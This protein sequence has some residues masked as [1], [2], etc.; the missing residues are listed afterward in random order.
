MRLVII[1]AI[2][3]IFFIAAKKSERFLFLSASALVISIATT[4]CRWHIRPELFSLLFIVVFIY[5]LKSYKGK[6]SIFFLFP[7]QV[8]WVNLHGYF[9]IGPI[10]LFIFLAARTA[11]ANLK[12]PFRWNSSK[13]GTQA[14]KK[15]VSVFFLLIAVSILNPY[16]F[17]G[18]AY[19]VNVF[20]SAIEGFFGG[21]YAF[22]SVSEL[23]NIPITHIILRPNFSLLSAVIILFFVS[24]LLN[25]KRADIFDLILFILFL[26]F[27]TAANRHIG[28]LALSLGILTIFNLNSAE[29]EK[30]F[31]QGIRRII[32]GKFLLR[33]VSI[34][35][36][37]F[38]IYNLFN[39][40]KGALSVF[41]KRYIYNLNCDTKS[42]MFGKNEF[43]FNQPFGAAEF[44]KENRIRAN[45]FNFFN[46]GAYLIFALYP[47]CRVFID[48]RTEVYGDTFL[49]TWHKIRQ[50]PELIDKIKSNLDI[51]CVVLPCA[52]NFT[53]SFFKYL[54]NSKEW[55]LVFF[56]GKSSVFL[57]DNTRFK[58]II[59]K[60]EVNLDN[61]QVNPDIALI[62]AAREE[63]LYPGIFISTA[64]FFYEIDM[65][66]KGLEVI[67]IAEQIMPAN[68]AIYNLKAILLL[69]LNRPKE[70][71]SQF[72]KAL[73]LQPRNPEI[74]KNIGG[75]YLER[76]KPDIA[77]KYFETGL[78][79]DPRNKKLKELLELL[80]KPRTDQLTHK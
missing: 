49:R 29:R 39:I 72:I 34:I 76:G 73:K 10:I 44:L 59:E 17:K 45:M 26:F 74:Y 75:F 64:N 46:H 22:S 36:M 57:A 80:N 20:F 27:T 68:Y 70:S 30:F 79:I 35:F 63:G 48:G 65:Y 61:F 28:M 38:L 50:N 3:C 58:V 43:T 23:A 55:R 15:L 21:S 32:A 9:I 56:D 18:A 51:D 2:L 12:L 16:L 25:L 40:T 7:L 54:Y 1:S 13:L 77:R 37:L 66:N 8:L 53:S 6:N 14:F 41:N 24:F 11:Q 19:P 78:Q 4:F 42:F 69:R 67:N 60:N 62:R 33:I 52:G 31:I 47:D 5:V 71:I